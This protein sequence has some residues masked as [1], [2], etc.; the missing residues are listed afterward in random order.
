MCIRDSFFTKNV[1]DG[2]CV[3]SWVAIGAMLVVAMLL[4]ALT[5]YLTRYLSKERIVISIP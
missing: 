1:I 3:F 4:L 2:M 5:T